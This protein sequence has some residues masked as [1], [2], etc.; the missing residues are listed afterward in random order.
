MRGLLAG[1]IISIVALLAGCYSLIYEGQEQ[2]LPA[3]NPDYRF[4]V[5]KG[6]N[7]A[8]ENGNVHISELTDGK[9]YIKMLHGWNLTL[10][11]W[12]PNVLKSFNGEVYAGG[13]EVVK[14]KNGSVEW[15]KELFEKTAGYEGTRENPIPVYHE[16]NL[17]VFDIESDGEYLY[18][19]TRYEIVKTDADLNV[20]RAV[21]LLN[22]DI[23]V[24]DGIYA[25]RENQVIKL[26]K[27]CE[28]RWTVALRSD[29]KIKHEIP[30]EKRK[31]A[32]KE[33]EIVSE[34]VE[35]EKY[36]IDL[37]AIYADDYVYVAGFIREHFSG[38]PYE[39]DYPFLV[40][41]ST[42]GELIWAERVNVT[43]P[44]HESN[45]GEGKIIKDGERYIAWAGNCLLVFDE[46]GRVLDFYLL[47][48]EI[49]DVGL[50]SNTIY[51]AS[52]WDASVKV[53]RKEASPVPIEI[54]AV[55]H[56][57][58]VEYIECHSKYVSG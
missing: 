58:E 35:V 31:E 49:T 36:Y 11:I 47:E 55:K 32:E 46:D 25:T 51:L 44:E 38:P 3:S 57:L 15:I 18:I 8:V 39:I 28:P 26:D 5:V 4:E 10:D 43:Y 20:V 56:Q 30:E 33:G 21:R 16:I 45:H 14:I 50:N 1:C 6:Y 12:N 9:V 48:G 2:I 37:Y 17:N 23:A 29:E 13:V 22:N 7:I 24:S 41:L 27:S 19:T 40:K 34:F 54:K 52:P 42:G 53:E